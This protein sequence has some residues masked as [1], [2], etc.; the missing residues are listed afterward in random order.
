M[1]FRKFAGVKEL[2]HVADINHVCNERKPCR[3]S[4]R[5]HFGLFLCGRYLRRKW[6][7]KMGHFTVSLLFTRVTPR[8]FN[9]QKQKN[10]T[11]NIINAL[12]G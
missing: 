9:A 5:S 6:R 2:K 10:G 7:L 8:V 1:I 12:G 11:N 4:S 3:N